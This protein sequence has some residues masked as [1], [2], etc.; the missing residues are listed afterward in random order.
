MSAPVSVYIPRDA[1]ALS[2]GA[3]EVAAAIQKEASARGVAVRIVRNGSRGMYWLEP[4]V[5]VVTPAGRTAYG[6]VQ[7]SDVPSLFSSNFLLGGKHPLSLGLTDEI[8]W[9][10]SQQRLTF[11]RVGIVD[12]ISVL[13]HLQLGRAYALSGD[14]TKAKIAYQDFLT[15]WKDADRDIPVLKQAKAEYAKLN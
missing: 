1:G 14:E 2:L 10:K 15:L 13:A 11:A 9:L 5:E 3:G 6:P 7:P 12:P 8:A 4:L